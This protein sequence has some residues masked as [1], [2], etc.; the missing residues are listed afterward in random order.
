MVT[1]DGSQDVILSQFPANGLPLG[2]NVPKNF[3]DTLISEGRPADSVWRI[4]VPNDSAFDQ[5]A[6][7][8]R[9][10][11][12]WSWS[13]SKSSTQCSIAASRSLRAGGVSL[14]SVVDGTLMPGFFNNNIQKNQYNPGNNIQKLPP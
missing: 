7:H 13:P 4:Y 11:H 10:L 8:E 12:L 6:A 9:G 2:Q 5:A 3:T 1:E 14:T